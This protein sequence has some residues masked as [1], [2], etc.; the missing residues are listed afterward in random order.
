MGGPHSRAFCLIYATQEF[1]EW[2]RQVSVLNIKLLSPGLSGSPTIT[3]LTISR[4]CF[5]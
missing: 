1:S 3:F 4:L 5:S 2:S